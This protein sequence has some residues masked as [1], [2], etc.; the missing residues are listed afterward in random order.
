MSA[1]LIVVTLTAAVG[2][3]AV[4]QSRTETHA[5]PS[6]N[7]CPAAKRAIDEASAAQAPALARAFEPPPPRNIDRGGILPP[8]L[9]PPVFSRIAY[10]AGN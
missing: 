1:V 10:C 3:G 7:V 8:V 5:L 4:P 6:L 2:A 9:S